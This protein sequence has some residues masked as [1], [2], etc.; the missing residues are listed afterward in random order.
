MCHIKSD[1]SIIHSYYFHLCLSFCQLKQKF[2]KVGALSNYQ[3]KGML[4]PQIDWTYLMATGLKIQ[5]S[6]TA[7]FKDIGLNTV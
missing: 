6:L 1:T 4:Q 7:R 2:C 5:H 3:L